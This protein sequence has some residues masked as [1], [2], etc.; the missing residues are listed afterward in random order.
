MTELVI[1]SESELR[2]SVILCQLWLQQ[3]QASLDFN[4]KKLIYRTRTSHY[5]WKTSHWPLKPT[6]ADANVNPQTPISKILVKHYQQGNYD[7]PD[8]FSCRPGSEVITESK[9]EEGRLIFLE[10]TP[11]VQDTFAPTNR[12]SY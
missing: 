8:T 7:P 9:Q 10:P 4:H 11:A 3:Y 6:T 2:E 12:F 1:Q 5:L